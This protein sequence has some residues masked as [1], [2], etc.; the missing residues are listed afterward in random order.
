MVQ[1]YI[2]NKEPEPLGTSFE[3]IMSW[4]ETNIHRWFSETNA[5]LAPQIKKYYGKEIG[6]NGK[7]LLLMYD[8]PAYFNSFTHSFDISSRIR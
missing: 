1:I 5:I 8:Y 4:D 2:E 7:D 3:D 6:I